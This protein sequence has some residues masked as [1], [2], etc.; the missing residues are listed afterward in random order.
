[1][2]NLLGK[3]HAELSQQRLA[4]QA[5]PSKA[6]PSRAK[7]SQAKPSQSPQPPLTTGKG[8]QPPTLSAGTDGGSIG[9]DAL[10]GH[11]RFPT[12]FGG[13]EAV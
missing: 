11:H 7:P 10:V 5:E 2:K 6:E 12:P 9:R 1:M 8:Q 3:F 4:S 13:W